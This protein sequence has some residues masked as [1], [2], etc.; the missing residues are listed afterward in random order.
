MSE[1][2]LGYDSG[3]DDIQRACNGL[4]QVL[5]LF[6]HHQCFVISLYIY[7]I[8]VQHLGEVNSLSLF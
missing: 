3:C 4:C 2:L 7:C 1:F 6:V 8:S 5:P